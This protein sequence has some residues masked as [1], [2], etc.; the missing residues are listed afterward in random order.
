MHKPKL[1]MIPIVLLIA[2]IAFGAWYLARENAAASNG[3]LT[4]SGTVEAVEVA[5]STEMTGRVLEVLVAKGD[6][7]QAGDPVL[8]LDDE[9]LQAQYARA[10]TAVDTAKANQD[11]ANTGLES[12]NAALTLA[13][14]GV[15]GAQVQYE[16]AID[17]AR[18]QEQPGRQRRWIQPQPDKINQPA[19]YFADTEELAA[20]QAEAEAALRALEAEHD[21]F[22]ALLQ[23]SASA[24]LKDAEQRLARAQAAFLVAQSVLEQAKAQGDAELEEAA[25]TLYDAAKAELEAAQDNFDRL[26]EALNS[27]DILNA[28]ARLAVA[29]E[30]Y[31]VALDR[32][33]KLSTGEASLQVK[34]MAVA[35]KQANAA[36]EQAKTNVTQAEARLEQ[37]EKAVS[38]A[39]AELEVLEVQLEKTVVYAPASGVVLVREVEPG[40]VI[41]PGSTVIVIGKLDR[42]TIT[43]YLPEDRYGEVALG[44]VAWV[45]VDSFPG[46]VFSARVTHIANQAEF[47]PRNVQ[48]AEGRRTTV[49]AV[50]LGIEDTEGKLKPGMPADVRFS[51]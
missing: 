40:E 42:L 23:S 4:A 25:Q 33:S 47:T 6:V 21:S 50:E 51:Q 7:V 22:E 41:Q 18:R 16:I 37:A 3:V 45:S 10:E 8:R 30:R 43:V 38:Q 29:Q 2:L 32:L 48:T 24:A 1:I 28:R 39:Q 9:L 49:F 12:A 13:E 34:A 26:I 14:I 11:I 36:V 20:A 44:E 17:L 46:R 31:D 19:W 27:E 15:E 5:V 35:L